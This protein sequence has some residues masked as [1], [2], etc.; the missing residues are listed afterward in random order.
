MLLHHVE[1]ASGA[2]LS[3]QDF[4]RRW[5]E[6]AHQQRV[7]CSE[8]Q[9]WRVASRLHTCIRAGGGYLEHLL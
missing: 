7:G 4:G 5:T 9:S 2:S 1:C 3:Y 8:S 6:T